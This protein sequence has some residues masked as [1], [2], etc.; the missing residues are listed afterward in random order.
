MIGPM[1][2]VWLGH[3]CFR[4]RGR[5][6]TV[7]TD[8]CPPSTG[9]KIGKVA[10]DIVTISHDHPEHNYRQAITGEPKFI[11]APGEFEVAGVLITGLRIRPRDKSSSDD[12]SQRNIAFVFDIDDIR[13]CHLGDLRQA[14]HADDVEPLV[15]TDILLIPV[16]GG[17]TLDARSAAETVSLLEPKIV[18][19]MRYKTAVSTSQVEGVEKFL[20]EMAAEGKTPESRLNISKSQLPADTTVVLLD[21]KG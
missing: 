14:P 12:R 4:L 18:I 15:G 7:V 9:Y 19:P 13:V 16:G 10:A 6:A 5:D 17:P 11:T 8:P 2:I 21:Y 20:K 1:E 3:S